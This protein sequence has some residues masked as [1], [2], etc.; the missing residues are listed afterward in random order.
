MTNLRDVPEQATAP[1]NRGP[2]NRWVALLVLCVSLLIV[3]LD[4]TILNVALPTLVR[5][6]DA[7]TTRLQWIV[8][9]Y[10]L[11]FTGLMLVAGSSAA[12][13]G[14]RRVFVTGLA[15]FGGM[16]AW[17]ASSGSTGMLIAAR[18]GWVRARR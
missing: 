16:S 10:A 12:R 1:R 2:A 4:N 18:A 3:T 15:V 6:L 13:F 17:A 11:V 8:D 14:R 5:E 9:A 7:S